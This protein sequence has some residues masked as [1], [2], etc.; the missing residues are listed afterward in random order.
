MRR[1]N[2]LKQ[3]EKRLRRRKAASSSHRKAHAELA[4]MFF[5]E[6][7]KGS[8]VLVFGEDRAGETCVAAAFTVVDRSVLLDEL[9]AVNPAVRNKEDRMARI[10]HQ[11]SDL[12]DV[13]ADL[14]REGGEVIQREQTVVTTHR[15][16]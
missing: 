1:Q 16:Q 9:P 6:I 8:N 15:K 12:L 14:T 4:Q 2:C 13:R 5:D 10:V 3:Q 7:Y 11:E